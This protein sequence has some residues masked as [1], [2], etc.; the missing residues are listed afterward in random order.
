M[1]ALLLFL[2]ACNLLIKL[3]CSW[4][5]TWVWDGGWEKTA[6]LLQ[7]L[8]YILYANHALQKKQSCLCCEYFLLLFLKHLLFTKIHIELFAGGGGGLFINIATA[9]KLKKQQQK[10][11][12]GNVLVFSVS[13]KI[14]PHI[15]PKSE[16]LFCAYAIHGERCS[17]FLISLPNLQA[18]FP[19]AVSIM[20]LGEE[21]STPHMCTLSPHKRQRGYLFQPYL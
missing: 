21:I 17:K 15:T 13:I 19:S 11:E 10:S 9:S 1:K 8:K 3:T 2:Q 16:H 12:L 5:L 18:M 4:R 7:S 6:L 20:D 14:L